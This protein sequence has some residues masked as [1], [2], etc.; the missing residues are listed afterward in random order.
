MQVPEGGV[1]ELFADG[2][3]VGPRKLKYDDHPAFRE[4]VQSLLRD[5][6]ERHQSTLF[7]QVCGR[8]GNSCKRPGIVVRE[9]DV[10]RIRFRLGL[11]EE[12]LYRQYLDPA[13]S[14]NQGDAFMRL[15]N[16]KCPF[17]REGGDD[18]MASCTIYSD[19]PLDCRQFPS[20]TPVCR[21]NPERL[22]EELRAIRVG[23]EELEVEL[24]SG[25]RHALSQEKP[26]CDLILAQLASVAEH[27]E[28]RLTRVARRTREI[29]AESEPG[30]DLSGLRQL[31]SDLGVIGRL[32]REQPELLETLW[33]ELR[34]RE[35]Q[36]SP[37]AD[38]LPRPY[39][40]VTWLQLTEEAVT[41]LY[42]LEEHP[43]MPVYLALSH[44]P[45]L[46]EPTQDFMRELLTRQ[47]EEFQGK[48]SQAD[49]PCFMCGECC[50]V[51]A[52]EITP[53]DIDRLT[54]LLE[55]TPR[56]FVDLHTL[57]GRF[58]WNPGNRILKKEPKELRYQAANP[59]LIPLQVVGQK[60]RFERGCIFLEERPDGFF[61]CTV[62]THKPTSC[63]EY[64]TTQSLCR[65][66]NQVQNW[67][68][69]ARQLVWVRIEES[70]L[71]AMPSSEATRGGA[72]HSFLRQ[73]WPELHR[74]AR[75]LEV[76]VEEV[77]EAARRQL[78]QN[79]GV[80]GDPGATQ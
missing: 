38:E 72:P 44:Y 3:Q 66:T 76:E 34:D 14:W 68:R 7:G 61:Y 27:G 79:C 53:G 33:G 30:S 77:L 50:R 42:Q 24:A 59:R 54:E 31:V 51:Y 2:F 10:F 58:S 48:L 39:H 19:R 12:E 60:E 13:P 5:L 35:R 23:A 4:Q 37:R 45:S 49:P 28:E 20:T 55:M 70:Q 15:Q 6:V 32:D 26:F 47:D 21:K 18:T 56:Q 43:P 40:R 36:V 52:V 69:Q 25:A 29:L 75:V 57:P 16:G 62:H 41:A 74:A 65:R 9:Q 46:L 11:T 63:R 73:D 67:G 1:V 71:L 22:I 17:L 78:N 80:G 8:C 64:E